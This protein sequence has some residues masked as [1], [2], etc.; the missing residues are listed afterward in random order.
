[1]TVNWKSGAGEV[2]KKKKKKQVSFSP[3]LEEPHSL[4]SAVGTPEVATAR[5]AEATVAG[6]MV[7]AS[8]T[9]DTTPSREKGIRTHLVAKKSTR[10]YR[11]IQDDSYDFKFPYFHK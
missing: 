10:Q 3:F 9:P 6:S 8:S 2:M 7:T 11:I 1:M 4:T 5:R